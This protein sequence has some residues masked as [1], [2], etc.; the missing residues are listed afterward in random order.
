MKTLI[1]QHWRPFQKRIAPSRKRV[2]HIIE[3]VAF[4]HRVDP[5]AIAGPSRKHVH[6]KARIDVIRAI[7]WNEPGKY[8]FPA[9]GQ[10]INRD[11]STV[12]YHLRSDDWRKTKIDRAISHLN[13]RKE[14]RHERA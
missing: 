2:R 9:I 7:Y 10:A 5:D 3:T 6:L 4:W 11:H 12:I 13:S 1:Y 14:A 8:S